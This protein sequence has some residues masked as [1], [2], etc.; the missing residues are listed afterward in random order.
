MPHIISNEN[1]QLPVKKSKL[2]VVLPPTLVICD[3]SVK[4]SSVKKLWSNNITE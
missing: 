1:L 3:A 4:S 2:R